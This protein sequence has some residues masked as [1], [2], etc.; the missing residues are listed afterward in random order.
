MGLSYILGIEDILNSITTKYLNVPTPSLCMDDQVFSSGSSVF[1]TLLLGGYEGG[2]LT[3]I[4]GPSGTGKTTICL[5]AAIATIRSR[6]KKV[7]FIDTEGGFSTTRLQQLLHGEVLSNYLDQFFLFKPMNFA[8]QLKIISR[9]KEL[10]NER[11]GLIIVDS[12]S[13]LYRI[14][15]AKQDHAKGANA[16]MGVQLFTLTTIA[17]T[18]G[19]PILLT[20]QVYADFEEKDK[21][22]IVGGDI[23]KYGS[24]CLVELEKYKTV[25]KATVIKHR[26]IPELKAIFFQIVA[27]G[28]LEF[29]E[30]HLSEKP[31]QQPLKKLV[32]DLKN[33]EFND[34]TD[35]G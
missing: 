17:R 12:I 28:F 10:M 15:L 14:E 33:T 29:E 32:S 20:T 2:V 21:V 31:L 24:K 35:L 9:L 3:T 30:Q 6:G 34:A 7:L 23:L 27:L 22:K 5:L 18:Y 1:D 25:R 4:Y 19:I 8:D 16:D 26:S 11:I 13:M